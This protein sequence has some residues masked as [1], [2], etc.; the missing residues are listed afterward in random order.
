MDQNNLFREAFSLDVVRRLAS[1][2]DNGGRS[3]TPMYRIDVTRFLEVVEPDYESLGYGE[4]ARRI[5]EGLEAVLPNEVP[6]AFDILVAAL[7]PEPVDEEGLSGFDGFYVVPL[8]MYVSR[9]GLDHLEKSLSAL[10]EMTKRFSAESEIRPFLERYPER[11]LEFLRELSADSSPYARRLASEG[12]R[13]RLPLAS[14]LKAFIENPSPVIDIL[15]LLVCDPTE[16]VRRSVAN[17]LNDI[18][19]DNPEVAVATLARWR[20]EF[21]GASTE[22]IIR[23]AARTLIKSDHPGALG[24]LGFHEPKLRV[25]RWE[26]APLRVRLGETLTFSLTLRSEETHD[27]RLAMNYVIHFVKSRGSRSRK[28]FRLPDKVLPAEGTLSIERRHVFRDYR[29]QRFYSGEHQIDIVV[30]GRVVV[31]EAFALEV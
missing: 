18:S 3:V 5:V 13:P 28:V 14:R 19:K 17:N 27:Q 26:A 21:P 7:G 8:T 23:H 15:D 16:L 12:T 1:M 2:I 22:R 29:N 31:T 25:E 9:H 4:R 11:T 6:R 24:L 20:K 30:N 10:Y